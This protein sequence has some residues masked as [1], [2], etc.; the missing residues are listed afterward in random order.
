MRSAIAI[1]LLCAFQ[2]PPPP[3]GVKLERLAAM[4]AARVLGAETIVV[5][6]VGAGL[7]PHGAHLSL[8]SDLVLA[9]HL[10]HRV[11]ERTAVTVAAAWSYHFSTASVDQ[12][13][14]ATL[15]LDTARD[16]TAELV[17]TLARSGPKRFYALNTSV[18]AAR[19]LSAAAAVLSRDGILLHFTDAATH[20][21]EH[22]RERETS[23]LLR[24]DPPSVN[25]ERADGD[26]AT[27]S[28]ARGKVFLDTLVDA[29]VLDI[30]AL[31]RATPPAPQPPEPARPT[32][33]PP[34]PEEP[35]RASG[36][37]AGDERSIA[38]LATRLGAYW[39]RRDVD[40]LAELWSEEGDL[41]HPDG[42]V[43]RSRPVIRENRR[44]QFRRKE[45]SA[46]K[47]FVRFGVVRCPTPDIAVAD[48][49]WELSGV[50]DAAGNVM[51]RGDGPLT[52]VLKKYGGT[53]LFEAYRYSVT[54]AQQGPK[55]PT[56]L[57]K[58]G[59]PDK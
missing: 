1:A 5:I 51:P 27:A 36:C 12:A 15:T 54:L 3:K 33:P 26:A 30:E 42:V 39:A 40:Q 29:I 22:A 59:Y 32:T 4:D 19:A 28:A 49:K 2:A 45:Y 21:G 52:V 48:G 43:E 57:K 34:P 14:T 37:T 31:R 46:S 24:I 35:R 18:T 8:G 6:P 13:G 9:E 53:W 55:P 58:P 41:V 7:Q 17:R 10:A 16:S 23:M 20:I 25:M 44:D 47:H 56:L 11:T 50:Y 38:D